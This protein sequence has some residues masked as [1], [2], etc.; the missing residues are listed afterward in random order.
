MIKYDNNT[1]TLTLIDNQRSELAYYEALCQELQLWQSENPLNVNL[2]ID[3]KGVLNGEVY[4][5]MS[6]QDI[7]SSYEKYFKSIELGDAYKDGEIMTCDIIITFSDNSA[8]SYKVA[9]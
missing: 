1:N 3:Y 6:L 4:L 5:P 7:I 9:I 8:K 2:G